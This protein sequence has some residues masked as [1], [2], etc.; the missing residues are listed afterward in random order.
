MSSDKPPDDINQYRTIKTSFKSIIARLPDG[1]HKDFKV[2]IDA[3][4]R[5]HRLTIL[6][7]QFIRLFMLHQ[8]HNGLPIPTFDDKSLTVVFR[9]LFNVTNDGAPYQGKNAILLKTL[10]AFYTKEF[11]PLLGTLPKVNA[12]RLSHV[13]GY[14][15]TQIKT[16][17]NNNIINNFESHLYRFVNQ[18][19]K[20][21]NEAYL[22]SLN[23]AGKDRDAK[24]RQLN[25][26]LKLV[27]A[28]FINQTLNSHPRFHPF[29]LKYRS[30]ILP[31]PIPNQSHLE[32]LKV[33]P[34]RFIKPMIYMNI[35]LEEQGLKQFQFLP[36]RTSSVPAYIEIDT[37]V[38]T[39]L[40]GKNGL[41]GTVDETKDA[42]WSNLFKI[43]K[44]AFKQKGF[45]F[46]YA[47][48]TDGVGVSIRFIS[49]DHYVVKNKIKKSADAGRKSAALANKGVSQ[50][51]RM[52][53]SK[54][55][56]EKRIEDSLQRIRLG[57]KKMKELNKNWSTMTNEEKNPH[58]E[59][60]Y[61][62]HLNATDKKRLTNA[63]KVYVDPGKRDIYT[64]IDDESRVYRYSNS[65]RVTETSRLEYQKLAA[66]H[67]RKLGITDIEK[68]LDGLNQK[69]CKYEKFK[70]YIKKK[71]EVNERVLDKYE[72]PLFRKLNWY[73]YINNQRAD[74]NIVNEI[75]E[76]YGYDSSGKK[77]DKEIVLI[78]G[79]WSDNGK[80]KY[81]STPGVRS[82]RLL[83][84][85][86]WVLNL[87]EYRTSCLSRRTGERMEK[88]YLKHKDGKTRKA[89][90]ILTYKRK[91]RKVYVNRD[92]DAVK[93][94]RMIVHEQLRTG[95]RPVNYCRGVKLAGTVDLVAEVVSNQLPVLFSE[96]KQR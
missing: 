63:K 90:A 11:L 28:D 94:M 82:K 10:R 46:D 55:K 18:S 13:L 22:D 92:R 96:K 95:K 40:F 58:L 47:I 93:S 31:L 1:Q 88:V 23:L 36:L 45:R 53:K 41:K 57:A 24:M 16:C 21:E 19:F 76:F 44:K 86:F 73:S 5:T 70:E 87:D 65:K 27:K 91:N 12:D 3:I 8:F 14:V 25:L 35:S 29:I 62:Q 15:R 71:N 89:H 42:V 51:D 9:C 81:M 59:F 20:K 49:D 75:K 80:L 34:Q 50:V 54:L 67:R 68:E 48:L 38:L 39:D 43:H 66:E 26:G 37:T 2:L 84:K 6:A 69:T 83:A 77:I 61:F 30:L 17:I 64:M 56:E 72:D 32:T 33:N 7:Y 78:M 4:F 60:P 79:D 52:A 74:A 85:K